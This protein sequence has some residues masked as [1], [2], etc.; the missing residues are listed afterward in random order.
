M[1]DQRVRID[2]LDS[3]GAPTGDFLVPAMKDGETNYLT[4]RQII[5]I[6][7]VELLGTATEDGDTLGE[8]LDLINSVETLAVGSE[9]PW[10]NATPPSGWF[11]QDGSTFDAVTYPLLN[12]H[13]GGNTLPDLRAEFIRGND[14]GRGI[15]SGRVL[16][17]FQD[18]EIL[19]HQHMDAIPHNAST[20]AGAAFGNGDIA[21]VTG[22]THEG[23]SSNNAANGSEIHPLTSAVGGSETRPRNVTKNWI[24]KHD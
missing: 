5:D 3:T 22:A 2:E 21:S 13:L 9:M 7:K 17:S 10:H 11:I 20:D 16:G 23:D 15:D 19:S 6:L 1:S 18:E 24:I 4:V 14:N 8:L 12:T